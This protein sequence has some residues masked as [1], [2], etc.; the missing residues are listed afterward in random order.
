[1]DAALYK[2]GKPDEPYWQATIGGA[3][4]DA[5]NPYAAGYGS[6]EGRFADQLVPGQVT[7]KDD[8]AGQPLFTTGYVQ[9]DPTDRLVV[10][11][12]MAPATFFGSTR[13][14]PDE[15]DRL[16]VSIFT[17]AAGLIGGPVGGVVGALVGFFGPDLLSSDVEVPC[18]NPII[19]ARH[20]WTGQQLLD[21]TDP[22]L[23]FGPGGPEAIGGCPQASSTYTLTISHL[24]FDRGPD[25]ARE[26]CTLEPHV[27]AVPLTDFSGSWGDSPAR[28][29]DCISVD[30][31]VEDPLKFVFQV[32]LNEVGTPNHDL[33]FEHLNVSE[34][35]AA[36][37]FRRNVYDFAMCAVRSVQPL[38]AP[39]GKFTNLERGRSFDKKS[40]LPMFIASHPGTRPIIPI[41]I[42]TDRERAA[43]RS[44]DAAVLPQGH[45]PMELPGSIAEM[46]GQEGAEIS[47]SFRLVSA[48]R[49]SR[50]I[51]LFL[52]GELHRG[53]L[54]VT[55]LRYLRTRPDGAI[56]TDVMLQ[57]HKDIP[58]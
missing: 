32:Q 35:R 30:I 2:P 20:E 27:T 4:L 47:P 45:R 49:C 3:P 7:R 28:A 29:T 8:A 46:I 43:H 33:K 55:R 24:T 25:V 54:Q 31:F 13:I 56:A 5:N 38:S 12:Y 15:R 42:N 26:G 50:D 14:G 19:S 44:G 37:A 52:Y 10:S 6:E 23:T 17:G 1:M 22:A 18:F 41:V 11:I 34:E 53:R 36:P 57:R 48:L 9:V 58:R 39:C 40:M 16:L 21:N 51:V